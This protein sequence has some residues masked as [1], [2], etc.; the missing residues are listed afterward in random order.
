MSETEKEEIEIV[1]T[2]K[3]LPQCERCGSQ[4]R[5]KD[6]VCICGGIEK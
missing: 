2:P 3:P 5:D 4:L 1:E 6:G